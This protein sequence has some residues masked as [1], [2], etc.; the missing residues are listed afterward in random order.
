MA[1]CWPGCYTVV[2]D[3]MM[4]TITWSARTYVYIDHVTSFQSL[5]L[6]YTIDNIEYVTGIGN[7][8]CEQY[9]PY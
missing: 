9:M 8:S 4:Q 5:A 2:K 1:I 6:L 7:R 3:E